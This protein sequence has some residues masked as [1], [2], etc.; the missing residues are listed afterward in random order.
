MGDSIAGT[1][2]SL[3]RFPVKS[4]LGESLDAVAVDRRGVAGDR[5]FALVDDETG[6]VVSVK[7]PRR[8][9]RIFELTASTD[10]AGVTVTF[11]DGTMVAIGDPALAARLS[12]FFG[13]GVS[14]AATPPPDALFDEAWV[15][16]LKNDA[17]PYFDLPSR[18][19][20]GDELID[21][22]QFMS[23]NGNFFNFGAVHL[24]TTGTTKRL[25]ELAPGTDFHPARFRPNIVVDTP[26]ADFVDTAWAGKTLTVGET[27]LAVSMTVP[28]CVMTTLRQ[29]EHPADPDVLRAI[30]AHNSVDP[31]FG[32]A[33]PCVGVYADVIEPGQICVGD[34]VHLA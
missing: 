6:R 27:R 2:S 28:R 20:E 10:T 29:G 21:A 34:A 1:V 7:R 5:Q 26:E 3:Y 12:E 9:G 19:E 16:E 32:K 11:P 22:G 30:T 23:A 8:W 24:V 33:Y 18:V 4:M 15:R 25:A 17:D 14:V 31:G 13:R